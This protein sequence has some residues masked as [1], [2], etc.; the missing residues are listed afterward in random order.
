MKIKLSKIVTLKIYLQNT[1]RLVAWPFV[2]LVTSELY[3]MSV[4]LCLYVFV[5]DFL[6]Y[7]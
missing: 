5:F 4:L 3:S 7:L 2:E 6:K 1:E